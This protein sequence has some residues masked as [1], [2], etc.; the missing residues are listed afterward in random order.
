MTKKKTFSMNYLINKS[1]E[2]RE[3]FYT[4]LVQT[5]ATVHETFY[6]LQYIYI[7]TQT[8]SIQTFSSLPKTPHQDPD[9]C[10]CKCVSV[11]V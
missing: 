3:I 5:L 2:V 10:L 9:E 1:S 11:P 7:F 6:H 4:K 8:L